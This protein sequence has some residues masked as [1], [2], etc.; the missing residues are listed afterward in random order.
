MPHGE[1]KSQ[2]QEE[3]CGDHKALLQ[4]I[5]D[6]TDA[7]GKFTD[8]SGDIKAILAKVDGIEKIN[9]SYADVHRELFNLDRGKTAELTELKLLVN[10]L[11]TQQA[12]QKEWTTTLRNPLFVAVSTGL[13][14]SI[15]THYIKF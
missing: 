6:F 4:R 12:G 8:A 5:S 2:Q 9:Q 13:I 3:H 15:V 1:L 7:V 11:T 14:I 10:T